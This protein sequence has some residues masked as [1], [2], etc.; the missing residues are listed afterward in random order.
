MG[1]RTALTMSLQVLRCRTW[2]ST[3]GRFTRNKV[4]PQSA[5][6]SRNGVATGTDPSVKSQIPGV[7]AVK[8]TVKAADKKVLSALWLVNDK[9][10]WILRPPS[11]FHPIA[12]AVQSKPTIAP[13]SNVDSSPGL[14]SPSVPVPGSHPPRP[15]PSRFRRR[16]PAR[17]DIAVQN[18][19]NERGATHK[20]ASGLPQG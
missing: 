16:C 12:V 15:R 5:S 13:D 3:Q 8:L 7:P 2:K 18:N 17:R 6:S 4:V 10:K 14:R 19:Q 1:G 11:N 20:K 9:L